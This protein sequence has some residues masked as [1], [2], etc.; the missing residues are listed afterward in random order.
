M[1]ENLSSRLESLQTKIL[2]LYEKDSTDIADHIE[3]WHTIRQEQVLL[4]YARRKGINRLLGLPVPSLQSAEASAK[5]AIEVETFL[6]SLARSEYGLEQWTLQQTSKERLRA[7]PANTFKKEGDQVTVYFDNDEDNEAEYTI[8]GFV[9][10]QGDDDVW[11]KTGSFVNH[12]GIFY[13]N[14]DGEEI[15]YVD[16]EEEAEKY[17][18]TATWTVRYHNNEFIDDSSSS[19]PADSTTT[20]RG[21]A[22]HTPQRKRERSQSPQAG[23]EAPQAENPAARRG[24]SRSPIHR[25]PRPSTPGL[26]IRRRQGERQPSQPSTSTPSSTTGRRRRVLQPPTA[27]EVGEGH[28]VVEGRSHSRLLQ[29]LREA[30]DPP[31]LGFSGNLN[32]LK[33]YRYRLNRDYRQYFDNV[34]TTW[35]WTTKGRGRCAGGSIILKF[36]SVGQRDQFLRNV[37][38]PRA[39]TPF[40]GSA[41]GL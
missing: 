40:I 16:F 1:E 31:I 19:V 36:N 18:N 9:Y 17:S 22:L 12:Q 10:Y 26:V 6:K 21:A 25:Q 11:H 34:S 24:R 3:L 7:D 32:S 38:F 4:F 5:D 20:A 8:W 15:Y 14:E 33:C 23:E 39:L 30:R 37:S 13:F 2:D 35:R 29:L 41:V 27:A 28:T